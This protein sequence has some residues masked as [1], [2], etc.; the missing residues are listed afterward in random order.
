MF[1]PIILTFVILLFTTSLH[2]KERHEDVVLDSLLSRIRNSSKFYERNT[3][4]YQAGIYMKGDLNINKRNIILKGIPYYSRIPS[5]KNYYFIETY[6]S[7]THTYPDKYTHS[8]KYIHHD[9]RQV[10]SFVENMILPHSRCNV[11]APYLYN[12]IYSPIAGKGGKYYKYTVDTIKQLNSTLQYRLNF[13]PKIHSH[14][15]V[16]GYAIIEVSNLSVRELFI[17]GHSEFADF[18]NHIKMGDIGSPD[19]FLIKSNSVNFDFTFLGNK[20]TGE[21]ISFIDYTEV[22]YNN[23][24]TEAQNQYESKSLKYD[25]T[26]KYHNHFIND[27]LILNVNI[28]SVRPIPLTLREKR[29]IE[30]TQSLAP[31]PK[32]VVKEDSVIVKKQ[33]TSVADIGKFLISDYSINTSKRNESHL[34]LSPLISPVLF[35][36]SS[37]D[38]IFYAQKLRYTNSYADGRLINIEPK[39]GYNFKYKEL[40]GEL[41]GRYKYNSKRESTIFTDIWSGNKVETNRIL[42]DLGALPDKVFQDSLLNLKRFRQTY[43]RIGWNTELFNG[44]KLSLVFALQQYNEIAKSDFTLTNPSSPLVS[45]ALDIAKHQYR[46]FVPELELEWT[47]GLYYYVKD[48]RKIP[49]YSK[50]PTI[51]FNWAYA[52]DGLLNNTTT[53]HRYEFDIQQT[54]NLSLN[55]KLLY[56][57][58]FGGF[59]NYNNLYFADFIKFRRNNNQENWD[60]VF[61]GSFQL[62]PGELYNSIRNYIRTNVSYSAPFLLIPIVFRDIP[63]LLRERAYFN[64]LLVNFNKPYIE[65]GY[66]IGTELFNASIFWGGEID[67]M[68]QLGI[69]LSLELFNF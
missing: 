66:G 13:K 35:R 5:N 68:D 17:S 57:V 47:P 53:Y 25:L 40:Y 49:L 15:L 48:N 37:N 14:Q 9:N 45:Q 4:D 27:S 31:K 12:K 62:L 32:P 64:T 6:G 55:Q 56:R 28:D 41:K 26:R 33:T 36:Y 7:L 24:N 50:Y 46:T 60:Y 58:G 3:P 52:I 22:S 39:I 63:H 11:Y 59:F 21:Y 29:V 19:Q 67:K 65:I 44:F 20:I 38:G 42:D 51:Y 2:S 43:A 18:K 30:E 16:S 10:R 54:L 61:S 23:S 8:F 69:K 34:E 1:R